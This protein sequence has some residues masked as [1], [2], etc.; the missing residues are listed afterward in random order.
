VSILPTLLRDRL[1]L[2]RMINK[3]YSREDRTYKLR[4]LMQQAGITSFKQLARL[5]STSVQS[6]GKIRS[7]E[8][9]TLRWQTIINL[10][11][12]LQISP[13]EL[14]ELFGDRSIDPNRQELEIVRQEYQHLQQQLAQQRDNLQA[15]FQHQ[16]L[17]IIESFLTYFPTAKHAA[18][19][20][21]DFPASKLL[22]IVQSIDKLIAHW[23]VTVIGTVGAEIPYDPQWHQSIEGQIAP[24]ELVTV[25]YVGYRQQDKLIFR[26]KVSKVGG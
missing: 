10:S 4:Q 7:G 26:A 19:N 12:G 21:P 18:S 17:Q 22:P 9:A 8:L 14:I 13:I 6:I 16:S 24:D 5:T 23:Q 2:F 1:L 20:N 3:K 15:E 25:R 11:T